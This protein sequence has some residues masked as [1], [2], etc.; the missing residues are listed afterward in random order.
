MG[1]QATRLTGCSFHPRT[2]APEGGAPASRTLHA[3]PGELGSPTPLWLK[4][5]APRPRCVTA[6]TRGNDLPRNGQT[7]FDWQGAQC[8]AT[9]ACTREHNRQRS[10]GTGYSPNTRLTT[11]IEMAWLAAG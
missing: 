4:R 7:V 10:G 9:P 3:S 11:A 5:R 2:F 8:P 6:C 1:S